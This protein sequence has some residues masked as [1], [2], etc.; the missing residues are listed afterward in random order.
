MSKKRVVIIGC[1]IAGFSHLAECSFNSQLEVIAVCSKTINQARDCAE[2]FCVPLYYNSARECLLQNGKNIDVLIISV[3]PA[4][5]L[6]ILGYCASFN[7]PIIIDKPGIF[8]QQNEISR[9]VCVYYS[10]RSFSDFSIAR[11]HISKALLSCDKIVYN[12]TGPY[13]HRYEKG[14]TYLALKNHGI[15]SDA[16]SHFF[17]LLLSASSCEI[18]INNAVLYNAPETSVEVNLSMLNAT[19]DISLKDNGSSSDSPDTFMLECAGFTLHVSADNA[20]VN[21]QTFIRDYQFPFDEQVVHLLSG[22]GDHIFVDYEN[23]SKTLRLIRALY[24]SSK[25]VSI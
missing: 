5:V 13:V 4:D 17:D 25:R 16:A 24:A 14:A 20:S 2:Q 19:I 18:S 9:R 10:R 1:G 8:I 22:N 21:A 11:E 3:P 12:A 7:F 23:N 15:L 6:E